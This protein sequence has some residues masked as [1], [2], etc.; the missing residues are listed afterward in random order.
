MLKWTR[1]CTFAVLLFGLSNALSAAESPGNARPAASS[2]MQPAVKPPVVAQQQRESELAK[3]V[4][5]EEQR[6]FSIHKFYIPATQGNL[7]W[8]TATV[9]AKPEES[10]VIWKLMRQWQD[11][12][13]RPAAAVAGSGN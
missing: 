13:L 5:L 11:P 9:R 3:A 8:L 10:L 1:T 7:Q 4:Q 12:S 6:H 2:E